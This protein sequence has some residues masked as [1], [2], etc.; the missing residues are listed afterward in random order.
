MRPLTPTRIDL[1]WQPVR[2]ATAY[3]V[4]RGCPRNFP[5]GDES[6]VATVR[7]PQYADRNLCPDNIYCFRVA[8]VI[9]KKEY[10]ACPAVEA[11]TRR[12]DLVLMQDSNRLIVAGDTFEA[13]WDLSNGGQ[14]NALRQYDGQDWVDVLAEDAFVPGYV[15]ESDSIVYALTDVP[16]PVDVVKVTPEE[17]CFAVSVRPQSKDGAQAGVEINHV[18]HVFREGWIFCHV[19]MR[20]SETWPRFSLTKASMSAR[21]HRRLCRGKCTWLYFDRGSRTAHTW[22]KPAHRVEDRRLYPYVAVDYGLNKELSFTNHVALLLEDAKGLGAGEHTRTRFGPG[23]DGGLTFEWTL[24]DGPAATI[25]AGTSYRNCWGIGLGAARTV[26]RGISAASGNNMIA[27]GYWHWN[28][29]TPQGTP[30][31]ADSD[32]WPWTAYRRTWRKLAAGSTAPTNEEID[33]QADMGAKI[34]VHH[35]TWMRSGGSNT[36]PPADYIPRDAD[37]LARM[38][39]H[40]HSRGLR[41]ALYMRGVEPWALNMPYWEQ[42]LT[43]DLDGLY[44]DWNGPL[45]YRH[46]GGLG[47]HQGCFKP[48]DEHVAAYDYFRY[49]KMLRKRVGDGG[50][51]LGHANMAMTF[52]AQAVFDGYLAGESD[53]QKE[54]LCDSLDAHVFYTMKNCCGGAVINYVG[55]PKRVRAMA[56]ATGST[57]MNERGPLWRM[58]DSIPMQGVRM[59]DSL[60][61]NLKVLEFDQPG[62]H[63]CV[64][65]A[66]RQQ[67]LITV[68]NLGKAA[69]GLMTIDMPTIGLVGTYR[70][71]RMTGAANGTI[72][73]QD[74]GTTTGCIQVE[75]LE[76]DAF[77]GYKLERLSQQPHLR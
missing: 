50:L 45:F 1:S 61:E 49:T 73:T 63:G 76:Q 21:L 58:W 27:Q 42:L 48:W 38:V 40:A 46:K 62:F 23:S 64:L 66:S 74:A 41:V 71:T 16:A 3:N 17:V 2:N 26:S 54:H 28:S 77:C 68:A 36:Y 60:T 18:F 72:I 65:R 31:G 19:R 43:R 15:I 22:N 34:L 24:H 10:P 4:Y 56:A 70:V 25:E 32:D 53:E 67:C 39:A 20:V 55:P 75:R 57:F 6:L 47:E 29:R 11:M 12:Q 9:A 59:F 14:I 8:P 5:I 51:L 35:Q 37:D 44:V 69:S 33:R 52:L 7:E 30:P 13:Q